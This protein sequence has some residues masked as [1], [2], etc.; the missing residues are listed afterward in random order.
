MLSS[1]RC[2]RRGKEKKLRE[3]G[4][5]REKEGGPIPIN[6]WGCRSDRQYTQLSYY[7][8]TYGHAA[9]KFK[10]SDVAERGGGFEQ[11]S[12]LF[13]LL[14]IGGD[15]HAALHHRIQDSEEYPILRKRS[16]IKFSRRRS[17][18]VATVL[19]RA[20][21]LSP[22]SRWLSCGGGRHL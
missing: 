2:F 21:G 15:A 3:K 19:R 16:C 13:P 11:H 4:R 8:L 18:V 17:S 7:L 9:Q 12:R 10:V 14:P 22:G 1:T 20:S 5:E 6:C